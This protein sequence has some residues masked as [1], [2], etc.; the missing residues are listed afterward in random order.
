MSFWEH[1]LPYRTRYDLIPY[2][3]RN[4]WANIKP[5]RYVYARDTA[6]SVKRLLLTD[7][8]WAPPWDDLLRGKLP[9]RYRYR[10]FTIPKKDGT[11]RQIAEPGVNLKAM[12]YR[13]MEH[14][15]SFLTPHHAAVGYRKG[16]SIADH[17]WAH[18]GAQTI[19]TADIADFFPSTT[20]HRVRQFWRGY[21]Y[22]ESRYRSRPLNDDEVQLL[23]NIT[24]YLGALPQGAPT[25]PMLSNLVNKE[26]DIRLHKLI[27]QS[28]GTYTRYADDLV[29]SWRTRARPPS[30]FETMVRRILREYG[31]QLHP[32]KGWG[33][34]SRADEPEVTGVILT[35][36]GGV[37]VP[38]PMQQLMDELTRSDDD[39]DAF[40]LEGYEA[41]RRMVRRD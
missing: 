36:R 1:F 12:Q 9:P 11:H 5:R 18:A 41:Y 33:V 16:M 14:F 28:S 25:S 4:L 29:F 15:L 40:R 26:M 24:T 30:D 6:A 20:R 8:Y 31:Y 10:H 7:D 3:F 13:V 35:R 32:R 34:W 23:T 39:Y 22:N 21:V 37:D 19:I 27:K 2:P 17:A 38:P